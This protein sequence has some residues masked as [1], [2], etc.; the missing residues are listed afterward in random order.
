VAETQ[1][2]LSNHVQSRHN[3]LDRYHNQTQRLDRRAPTAYSTRSVLLSPPTIARY[4]LHARIRALILKYC[5]TLQ[6]G[7]RSL[8]KQTRQTVLEA[9]CLSHPTA[10]MYTIRMFVNLL[11]QLATHHTR[12]TKSSPDQQQCPK[13]ANQ[14][15]LLVGMVRKSIPQTTCQWIHGH[16]NQRRRLQ[17]KLTDLVEIETSGLEAHRIRRAGTCPKTRS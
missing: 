4:R 16:L 8:L 14:D 3:L 6:I 2:R 7:N 12:H 9:A 13:M 11:F 17:S 10:S 15:P 5:A 1:C